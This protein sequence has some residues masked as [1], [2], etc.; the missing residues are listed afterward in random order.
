MPDPSKPRPV[1]RPGM[2]ERAARALAFKALA[3]AA[4]QSAFRGDQHESNHYG[5]ALHALGTCPAPKV[6]CEMDEPLDL[7]Q[8]RHTTKSSQSEGA[9]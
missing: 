9:Q 2:L 3:F 6:S 7:G 1:R 4:T 8:I 5:V